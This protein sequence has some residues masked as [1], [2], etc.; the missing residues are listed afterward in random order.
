LGGHVPNE[1]VRSDW[2]VP[3]IDPGHDEVGGAACAGETSI[4]ARR[5]IEQH[6]RPHAKYDALAVDELW[7]CVNRIADAA[8]EANAI[9]LGLLIVIAIGA[10][11]LGILSSVFFGSKSKTCC[12]PRPSS[13]SSRSPNLSSS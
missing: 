12:F 4:F 5:A 7:L 10:I 13:R 11:V 2:H 3:R 6:Q 8:V 9:D 1:S